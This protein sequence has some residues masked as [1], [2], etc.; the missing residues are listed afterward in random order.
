[1][2]PIT[3]AANWFAR[4]MSHAIILEKIFPMKCKTFCNA[5]CSFVCKTD[6]ISV[7]GLMPPGRLVDDTLARSL[8]KFSK[9][10]ERFCQVALVTLRSVVDGAEPFTEYAN[11]ARG[12]PAAAISARRD[13]PVTTH[14]DLIIIQ[15]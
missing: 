5:D 1:M 2:S 15:L 6:C 4:P 3:H 10:A 8:K 12:A 13:I 14:F 9:G 7:D 11:T